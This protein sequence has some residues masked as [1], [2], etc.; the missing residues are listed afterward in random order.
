MINSYIQR[1]PW[2]LE[3]PVANMKI[4]RVYVLLFIVVCFAYDL[5][6]TLIS[7]EY[8]VDGALLET[9]R[10]YVLCFTL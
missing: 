10:A 7:K 6:S 3:R 9:Y 5:C 2:W 4:N 8:S 1:R